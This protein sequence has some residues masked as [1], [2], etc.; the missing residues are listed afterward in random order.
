MVDRKIKTV[1]QICRTAAAILL[2]LIFLH[3]LL[4]CKLWTIRPIESKAQKSSAATPAFNADSYVDSIWA[5]KIVPTVTAKAVDLAT[6]L[7]ALDTNAEAAK[8]QFGLQDGEGPTHFIVKGEGVISRVESASPHRTMT[9]RLPKYTG[10]TEVALQLGPVFRGTSLRD[11]V[12]FIR[13]NEF[14]NQ[15]QY[16]EVSTKLNDRVFT[17]VSKN[18]DLTSMQGKAV[19]FCG[20]FTLNERAKI[21][22]TPVQLDEGGQSK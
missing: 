21:M 1:S 7:T 13:F 6:L 17:A 5:N 22:L 9:I 19:S 10:K 14:V 18:L 3:S 11:A 12:G 8:K 2:L 20:V 4:A 15:L 16:A